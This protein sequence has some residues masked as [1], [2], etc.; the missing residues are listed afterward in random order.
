MAKENLKGKKIF[1]PSTGKWVTFTSKGIKEA[2]NQP[3]RHYREKNEAIRT[4]TELFCSSEYVGSSLDDTREMYLCR[5]YKTT[6]AEEDSFI[7]IREN[8][9][10]GLVEFYTIVDKIKE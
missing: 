1:E 6:I 2:A 7:V 3:H 8:R 9:Y 4:I 5:Y 10:T